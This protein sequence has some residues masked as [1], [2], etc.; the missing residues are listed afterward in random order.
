MTRTT[1]FR[2]QHVQPQRSVLARIFV[3]ASRLSGRDA[4]GP[5][6][7][8]AR[9]GGRDN[10]AVTRGS[11]LKRARRP[12]SQYW[13]CAQTGASKPRISSKSLLTV[14]PKVVTFSFPLQST[15]SKPLL[16]RISSGGARDGF[17]TSDYFDS[18]ASRRD[19]YLALQQ[20]LG[21]WTERRYWSHPGNRLD[22][23]IAESDLDSS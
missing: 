10:G 5:S 9:R 7:G 6:L 20:K 16:E 18:P 8:A 1:D 21:L 15:S 17:D 2:D 22:P 11:A 14:S 12:R 13:R 23:V 4:R 19:S 3:R